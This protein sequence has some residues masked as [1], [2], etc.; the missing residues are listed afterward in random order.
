M[1][2]R[3]GGL[4]PGVEKKVMRSDGGQRP[5]EAKRDEAKRSSSG[6]QQIGVRRSAHPPFANP[7]RDVDSGQGFQVRQSG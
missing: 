2:K 6:Q 3:E 1:H 5:N 7:K 4:A